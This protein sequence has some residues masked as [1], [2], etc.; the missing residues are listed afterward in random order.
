MNLYVFFLL[1][2]CQNTSL[3]IIS[4]HFWYKND[5]HFLLNYMQITYYLLLQYIKNLQVATYLQFVWVFFFPNPNIF[6]TV[7]CLWYSVHKLHCVLCKKKQNKGEWWKQH[8]VKGREQKLILTQLC[9]YIYILLGI[10]F[11]YE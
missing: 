7:L 10:Y 11:I 9:F 5:L 4:I 6:T 3:S 8:Y 1:F 2:R